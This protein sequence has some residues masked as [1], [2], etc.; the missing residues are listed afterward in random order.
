MGATRSRGYKDVVEEEIGRVKGSGGASDILKSLEDACARLN[1][2]IDYRE[3][4]R[5][6]LSCF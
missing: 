3:K 2:L 1:Q 5:D 4:V 6:E